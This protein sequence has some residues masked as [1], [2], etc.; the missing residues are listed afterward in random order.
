MFS[1]MVERGDIDSAYVER[2]HESGC[3]GNS[4]GHCRAFPGSGAGAGSE[5]CGVSG[6]ERHRVRGVRARRTEKPGGDVGDAI[7]H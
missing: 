7:R 2:D 3:H 6:A 5:M 1:A 4:D